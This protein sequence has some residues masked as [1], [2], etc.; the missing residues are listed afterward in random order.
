MAN[1]R[2][3]DNNVDKTPKLALTMGVKTII[4][5]KEIVVLANGMAKSSAIAEAIEGGISSMCPVT[6]LQMHNRALI[7]CDEFAAFDL[8]LRTIRYFEN[9]NDEYKVFANELDMPGYIIT[10]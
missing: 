5:A 9:L 6:A 1:S 3:F 10:T 2:F 4:N 8:K 7:V